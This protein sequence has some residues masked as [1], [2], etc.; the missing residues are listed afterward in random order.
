MKA[1]Q[2]DGFTLVEILIVVAIVGLLASMG[3]LAIR[4]SVE[5]GR[6]KGAEAELQLLSAAV[7]QMAWDTGKW[8]NQMAR[9]KGGSTEI[10]NISGD[11]SGLFLSDGSYDNWKGPYYNGESLDPWG[12]PYFFD[13]DYRINGVNH[14][15]VGSFGPN[16]KGR[17]L[18]DS[19]DIYVLLD[20]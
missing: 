10:W 15:V 4:Q 3:S 19:D 7:L 11:S 2:Q 14:V 16:G 1:E 18:Y 13:P 5:N 12:N 8:P 17:N 9:N 6:K 20:D